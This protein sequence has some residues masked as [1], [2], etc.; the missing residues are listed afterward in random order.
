[1]TSDGSGEPGIR[2][3]SP[4]PSLFAHMKYGSRQRVGPKIRHLAPLD[5][6]ACAIEEKNEFTEDEKCHN[7]MS[8]LIFSFRNSKAHTLH[9]THIL[10]AYRS[11]IM[12]VILW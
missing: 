1:M 11:M 2:A 3:V 6:C 9:D 10:S 8:W 4:E 12:D 7:L 5:G